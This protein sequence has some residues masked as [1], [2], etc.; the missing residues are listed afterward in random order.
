MEFQTLTAGHASEYWRLRL[1]ALQGDPDAFSASAEE[2]M[3]LSMDEIR[4]RLGADGSGMLVVGAFEDGLLVGMAGFYPERGM[5][6]RHKGR[7]WGVYVTPSK[8]GAGVGRRLLQTVLDQG[9]AVPGIEQILLSV[10]A[11]QTAA[12]GLY[13]S[14]GFESFGREPRALKIGGRFVDEEYMILRL[15]GRKQG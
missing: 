3:S 13:R 15:D 6:S 9:A 8:R 11:T 12:I 5:K 14:L 2:H 4:R 1:E 7:V 10:T